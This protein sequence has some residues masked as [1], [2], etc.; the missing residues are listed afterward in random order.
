M[1]S[2]TKKTRKGMYI[3]KIKT[4]DNQRFYF[5]L[6]CSVRTNKTKKIVIHANIKHFITSQNDFKP[7]IDKAYRIICLE[8]KCKMTL[9]RF[10]LNKKMEITLLN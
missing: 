5:I 2:K 8:S 10:R 3:C 6:M 1:A 7:L 9:V 4:T